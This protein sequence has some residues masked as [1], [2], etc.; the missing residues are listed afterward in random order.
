[1]VES[2]G[3]HANWFVAGLAQSDDR[4]LHIGF[5]QPKDMAICYSFEYSLQHGSFC[6]LS[7]PRVLSF[8]PRWQRLI[9]NPPVCP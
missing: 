1:M 9:S 6:P 3:S 4:I 5:L 2:M 7:L 8:E